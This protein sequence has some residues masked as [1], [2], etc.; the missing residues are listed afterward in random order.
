MDLTPS[1]R[2]HLV[3]EQQLRMLRVCRR[4]MNMD[5]G[6]L[7]Q[8]RKQRGA[9]NR[10]RGPF[11][12]W[13]TERQRGSSPTWVEWNRALCVNRQRQSSHAM[14]PPCRTWNIRTWNIRAGIHA[15]VHALAWALAYWWDTGVNVAQDLIAKL[16]LGDVDEKKL[17]SPEISP[18]LISVTRRLFSHASWSWS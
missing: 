1:G 14:R 16:V 18:R 15:R 5:I 6:A 9:R 7:H 8:S 12:S 2:S 17:N 10:E 13:S 11:W 3:M 4:L